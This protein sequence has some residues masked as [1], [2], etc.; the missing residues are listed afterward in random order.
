MYSAPPVIETE[1]HARLPD[2]L[3]LLGERSNWIDSRDGKP[4]HSFLEGPSFDRDGNFYCVDIPFGRIFKVTPNGDWSVFARY[5]GEPNG[6]K[7]HQ[8]GRIFVADNKL[9]LLQ[10][11]PV[12]ADYLV[13]HD[14]PMFER[15]RGLNDLVFAANGDIYFTDI[16]HSDLLRP[17]G[18]VF[19][20]RYDGQLDLVVEGIA[21][22]N[23]LVLNKDE[24]ILYV[25]ATRW[26]QVISIP[27]RS[28]YAGVGKVGVFVQLLGGPVG[29]DGMAMDEDGNLAVVA[30]GSGTVW[31]F[32]PM[33]EPIYRIRSCAGRRTTNLAY[34]GVGNKTLY[35]TEAEQGV[36]LKAEMPTAG[37]LMYSHRTVTQ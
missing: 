2:N 9:G 34:G 19:R 29:P 24:T 3:R 21:G 10:F 28:N 37:R 35:I 27:L 7:I 33:G 30:A 36:I 32:N 14:R 8:D 12:T 1:V 23:G 13:V 25:A 20:L 22:P 11:D 17:D 4:M 16:G 6:L 15:F 26:N 18:R 31:V 5:D